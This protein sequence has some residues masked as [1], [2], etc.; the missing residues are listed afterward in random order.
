MTPDA[1]RQVLAE[2]T[3]EG[4]A[5]VLA[6]WRQTRAPEVAEVLE[7]AGRALVPRLQVP[8]FRN[9][10]KF[11]QAWLSL[12]PRASPA[13]VSFL[14]E[15]LMSQLPIARHRF[16]QDD[17]RIPAFKER[18]AAL[19]ASA[20]D[21]RL[22]AA[23]ARSLVET[24]F[25]FASTASLRECFEQSVPLITV[26]H[27]QAQ[28]FTRALELP[29]AR[30]GITRAGLAEVLPELGAACHL[31]ASRLGP[32][33]VE[34]WRALAPVAVPPAPV[35]GGPELEELLVD[36]DNDV[37]RRVYADAL[38]E[39]GVPRGEFIALQ[40]EGSQRPAVVKRA[41]A[42][43]KAHQAEWLGA[44]DQV[45]TH[46]VFERGFLRSAELGHNARAVESIWA[47]ATRHP[48]LRFVRRL[49]QGR[50]SVAAYVRFLAAP[51]C[52]G[53]EDLDVPNERFCLELLAQGARP[54][55]RLAFAIAP[56]P[57]VLRA[58]ASAANLPKL[59]TLA[60]DRFEASAADAW[61]AALLG[62][63][64]LT[65]VRHLEVPLSGIRGLTT[66]ARLLLSLLGQQQL[67][68]VTFTSS[69]SFVSVTR[70]ASGG[71]QLTG[72][73]EWSSVSLEV[74]K[75]LTQPFRAHLQVRSHEN[76][77]SAALE[78]FASEHADSCS[79]VHLERLDL[80]RARRELFEAVKR[81]GEVSA[82]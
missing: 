59:H 48:E 2:P 77:R 61:S 56:T 35:T 33:E 10:E 62:S 75:S 9:K 4:V 21:P 70:G 68:R 46:L 60:L 17:A 66:A 53:L 24:P 8:R 3:L 50:G 27:R 26:D 38:I 44:L 43:L 1:A 7:A 31:A 16:A 81:G 67:A 20:P 54:I 23:L 42:L 63:G 49:G 12:A 41:R 76:D 74:L 72:C 40:L 73:D 51:G 28:T 19:G 29:R 69:S 78:R 79:L 32:A 37:P 22:S 18:V 6:F 47:E 71:L 30:A 55:G 52:A 11:Q 57:A 64:L 34:A 39:R 25:A 65:R 5:A 82:R 13:E 36:E 14:C 58:L 15:T 45:L 80:T